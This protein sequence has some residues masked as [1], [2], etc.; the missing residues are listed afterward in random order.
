MSATEHPVEPRVLIVEDDDSARE[1]LSDCLEMEGFSVA[2][3]RNG[4][5]AL[6]YLHSAPL[7]KIILLDLYMP[8][9]TGWEFREAQK[10][11][12]AIAHIPV[13]VVTAF[14]SGITKQIDADVIMHKPLDLDRLLSVIRDRC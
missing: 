9:M 14:G 8:V 1:A 10:K 3:A 13:V 7:P 11:D 6:D 12:A 2:S 5:E 4:K